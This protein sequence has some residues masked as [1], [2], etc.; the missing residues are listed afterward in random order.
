M[1]NIAIVALTFA[2]GAMI[3]VALLHTREPDASASGQ[4][5]QD[6]DSTGA[7]PR[8][9]SVPSAVQSSQRV[10]SV[11]RSSYDPAARNCTPEP[12]S[13]IAKAVT[14]INPDDV[15]YGGL[16]AEWRIAAVEETIE[17]VY[18]SSILLLLF[19]LLLLM[20]YTA[21]L[22]RQ[23]DTRLRISGAVLAQVWNAHIHAR[24]K[25]IETIRLHN[26]WVE[27]VDQQTAS[28]AALPATSG[29][30][31]APA[32]STSAGLDSSGSAQD[33]GTT[34]TDVPQWGTSTGSSRTSAVASPAMI[35]T[36]RLKEQQQ[37]SQGLFHPD[38]D[39]NRRDGQTTLPLPPL[40][41][42]TP[43]APQGQ[44][45]LASDTAGSAQQAEKLSPRAQQVLNEKDRKIENLRLQ[46]RLLNEKLT[47]AT[48][49]HG[50][51]ANGQ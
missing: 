16:L 43:G 46:I 19:A 48:Q 18:W 42:E 51:G 17:S 28:S 7:Q 25:A 39:G 50:H 36:A 26:Q 41:M 44:E 49:L 45:A 35:C 40:R 13:G 32:A 10:R 12:E 47:N 23:R 4:S 33:A 34:A 22:L 38:P 8:Q 1:K 2:L 21:W 6:G 29:E 14:R 24:A 30:K 27:I 11:P 3:F 31:T 5:V 15:N 9:P 37:R 20:A